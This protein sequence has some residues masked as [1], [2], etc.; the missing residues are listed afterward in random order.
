[1]AGYP[2]KHIEAPDFATD[3]QHLKN[4]VAQGA[5]YI[6]TQMFFD[7]QKYFHFVDECRKA[8]IDVPIIPGLKPLATTKQLETLP[9][10][11]NIEMPQKLIAQVRQCQSPQEVR[12]VGQAWCIAQCRELLAARVPALHFYTMS[13]ADNVEKVVRNIFG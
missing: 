10:I 2:E 6:V 13:K 1:V 3:L 9:R 11:F 5:D 12:E 7:N 8:G 4:K